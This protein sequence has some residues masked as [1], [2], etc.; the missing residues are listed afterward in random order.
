MSE[1]VSRSQEYNVP[2]FP[3]SISYFLIGETTVHVLH[4]KRYTDGSYVAPTGGK[5][6][7]LISE[8]LKNY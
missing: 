3:L 6:M 2:F 7:P 4:Y 8:K 1:Q 5:Q